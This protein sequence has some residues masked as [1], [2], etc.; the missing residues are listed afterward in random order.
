MKSF[1]E[2]DRGAWFTVETAREKIL[3]RQRSFIDELADMI[4]E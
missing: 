3:E 4:G 1:P 2:I